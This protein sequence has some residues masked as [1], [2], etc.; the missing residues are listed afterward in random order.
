MLSHLFRR[1]YWDFYQEIY[2]PYLPGAIYRINQS[3][4]RGVR[5]SN[6]FTII[7]FFMFWF[8]LLIFI[9]LAQHIWILELKMNEKLLF[10]HTMYL[11]PFLNNPVHVD[12]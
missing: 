5:G 9:S 1:K 6:S 2:P 11:V 4:G 3:L 7:Q 12:I 10:Y 8:E